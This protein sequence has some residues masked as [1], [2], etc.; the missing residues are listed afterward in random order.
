MRTLWLL[1]SI[2][3]VG[4]LRAEGPQFSDP[5]PDAEWSW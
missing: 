1:I 3:G 5:L 4:T 2:V